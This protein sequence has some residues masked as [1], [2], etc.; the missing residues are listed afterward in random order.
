VFR[1]RRNFEHYVEC[2]D[3]KSLGIATRSSAAPTTVAGRPCWIAWPVRSVSRD[4]QLRPDRY[5]AELARVV[6][7]AA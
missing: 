1:D 2:A 7:R 5:V 4:A 6:R 3:L